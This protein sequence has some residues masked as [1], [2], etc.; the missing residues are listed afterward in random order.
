V[1]TDTLTVLAPVADGRVG[2]LRQAV[3]GLPAGPESPFARVF[4]THVARLTV[5]EALDDRCLQP[6]PGMGSFLL[7]ATDFDGEAEVHVERLRNGLGEYADRVFGHCAG[8]PGI[9]RGKA[10]GDWLLRHRIPTGFSVAPYRNAPV[11]E[12]RDV[13]ALRRRMADF[14]IAAEALEPAALKAA[15]LREF[16]DGRGGGRWP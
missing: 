8:Y 1:K 13:L 14:V 9:R 12:V 16:G 11:D 3:D 5:I 2:A 10:F 15:W 6:D 7:F 4:G